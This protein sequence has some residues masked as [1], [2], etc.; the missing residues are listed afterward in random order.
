[1]TYFVTN[2]YWVGE[3]G[4]IFL[5]QN[6][7]GSRLRKVEEEVLFNSR[8]RDYF[9]NDARQSAV[10]RILLR[11]NKQGKPMK[12]ESKYTSSRHNLGP[13]RTSNFI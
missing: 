6:G 11:L 2:F 9:K 5:R 13:I 12:T 1:M 7:G 10:N 3:E 8:H 4:E